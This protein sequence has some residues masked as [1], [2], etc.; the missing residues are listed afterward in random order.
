[1]HILYDLELVAVPHINT[2]TPQ[3]GRG[4]DIGLTVTPIPYT[5]SRL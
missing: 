4:D 1:M 5:D 2:Q 3:G